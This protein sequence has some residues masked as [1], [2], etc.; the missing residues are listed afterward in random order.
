MVPT[1]TAARRHHLLQRRHQCPSHAETMPR[2]KAVTCLGWNHSAWLMHISVFSAGLGAPP[3]APPL[4][5]LTLGHS[6]LFETKQQPQLTCL[7][8]PGTQHSAC[9]I[10]WLSMNSQGLQEQMRKKHGPAHSEHF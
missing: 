5:R 2:Y 1:A 6:T 9:Y 10:Q 4:A 7:W 3:P 8:S